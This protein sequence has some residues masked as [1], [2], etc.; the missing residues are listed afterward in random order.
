MLIVELL[1]S[2]YTPQEIA[3]SELVTS[4]LP[5]VQRIARAAGLARS[6]G[7]PEGRKHESHKRWS[8]HRDRVR[9]L[10]AEGYSLRTIAALVGLR[11]PTQVSNLLDEEEEKELH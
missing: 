2:G 10:R 5:S 6:V 3:G 11:S 7:A 4:S 1:L 8:R 9:Q